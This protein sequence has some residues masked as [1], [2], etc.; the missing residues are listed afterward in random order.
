MKNRYGLWLSI[1]AL[2]ATFAGCSKD[3][4]NNLTEEE[5]RIYITNYDSAARF[6]NYKTYSISDS[7]AVDNNG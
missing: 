5:S 2:V 1:A 7:V 3:P 6:T 4:L